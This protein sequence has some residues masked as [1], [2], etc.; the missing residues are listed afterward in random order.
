MRRCINGYWKHC[1]RTSTGTR[2]W[3]FQP[4]YTVKLTPGGSD[5]HPDLNNN[6]HASQW[7]QD[8]NA[9]D[10]DTSGSSDGELYGLQKGKGKG[11]GGSLNGM[12]KQ[13][14]RDSVAILAQ[15]ISCSNVRGVVAVHELF[16][17]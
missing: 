16:W 15:A 8:W 17:F 6:E 12:E 4:E 5:S 3:Q 13:K 14:Q 1:T 7:R 11:K 9:G 10:A 2:S